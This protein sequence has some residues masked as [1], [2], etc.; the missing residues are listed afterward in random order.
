[1]INARRL[2]GAAAACGKVFVVGGYS[3]VACR[4]LEATCEMFDP[5]VSQGS[6][7][8][9]PIVPRAASAMVSFDDHLYLFG[10]EN[11]SWSKHDSVERYD[12]Q[13]DK[14]EL[15]GT[16]PEKL[17]CVLPVFKLQCCYCQRNIYL[18]REINCH[19][20]F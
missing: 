16:M 7:V 12:V 9:S 18:H 5:L 4:T 10:G 17:A 2:A 14:W 6:L 11:A 8:S 1:M 15:F 20:H 3:D 19:T 13:N